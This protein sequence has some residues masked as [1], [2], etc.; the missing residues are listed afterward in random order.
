MKIVY[1]GDN[2]N[3]DNF[4]CRATSTALSQII[5]QENTIVGRIYGH[6]TNGD[7]DNVFY[8]KG[9]SEN[10][11]KKITQKHRWWYIRK[12]LILIFHFWGRKERNG[13]PKYDFIEYNWDKSITNLKKCIPANP[14]LAE[15]DLDQYDYDALVVNGE[16]SFIFSNRPWREAMVES[17]LMYWAKKQGKKVFFMNAMFSKGNDDELNMETVDAVK[18]IFESIDYVGVREKWSLEMGKKLFPKANIH[19]YPDALFSW[20][21][22]INDGFNIVDGKYFIGFSGATDETFNDYRFDK[23]YICLSGSSSRNTQKDLRYTIEQYTKLINKLK[24]ISGYNVYIVIPCS[25]DDFLIEVSKTTNTKLIPVDTPI[26]AAGKV[27]AN[28][29]V[30][31]TGRYHPAILASLGGTPCVFMGSN[32]HKNIS[33]Q[34]V[35][36]YD[37]PHEYFEVPD[38]NDIESIVN[39]C[40][41]ILSIGSKV[42]EKIKLRSSQLSEI[43]ITMRNEIK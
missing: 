5:S 16:G 12:F 20:Y 19:L 43:S 39:E 27:L 3:R 34:E 29:S 22:Y 8:Y 13:L 11:Y 14:V 25:G 18:S 41:E 17:M 10:L 36:E 31:V 6:Y 42:R 1:V 21:G 2:R 37:N 23:P 15:C 38:E 32:S 9:L 24:T 28:A 4:G 7:V 35:L 30:Y 33:I 26:L 40:K